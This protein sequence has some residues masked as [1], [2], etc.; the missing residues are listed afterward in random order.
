[1]APIAPRTFLKAAVMFAA[2]GGATAV[3][4]TSSTM[5]KECGQA[6]SRT[7]V[8][9]PG[10]TDARPILRAFAI[11]EAPIPVSSLRAP[12]RRLSNTQGVVGS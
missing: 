2:R 1:V 12:G 7:G 11:S 4:I 8:G 6:L 9:R 5:K 3:F 10:E